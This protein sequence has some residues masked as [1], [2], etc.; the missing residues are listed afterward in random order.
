MLLTVINQLFRCV[1]QLMLFSAPVND[2]ENISTYGTQC[3]VYKWI[4]L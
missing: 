3:S 2:E 4:I 1:A